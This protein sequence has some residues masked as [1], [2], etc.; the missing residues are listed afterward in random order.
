MQVF[1]CKIDP[2][3][4]TPGKYYL[5]AAISRYGG[6]LYDYIEEITSIEILQVSDALSKT[7]YNHYVGYVYLPYQWSK[8]KY[9]Y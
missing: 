3:I 2:M 6:E 7:P 4:L 5:R 8:L 9:E 1:Q